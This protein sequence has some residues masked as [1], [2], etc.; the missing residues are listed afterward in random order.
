MLTPE[1]ETLALL[2]KLSLMVCHV[3]DRRRLDRSMS[4]RHD[5]AIAQGLRL[6]TDIEIPA[7]NDWL[8]G[9]DSES[10]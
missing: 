3:S 2:G 8:P 5:A 4:V 6:L 9:I 10:D 7:E 1:T